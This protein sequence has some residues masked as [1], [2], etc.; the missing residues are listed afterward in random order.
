MEGIQWIAVPNIKSGPMCVIYV[1]IFSEE[2][3]KVTV[4]DVGAH[5]HLPP[6]SLSLYSLYLLRFFSSYAVLWALPPNV[7]SLDVNEKRDSVSIGIAQHKCNRRL[8]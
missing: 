8:S 3:K 5:T 7:C 2:S 4:I 1:L 6:L